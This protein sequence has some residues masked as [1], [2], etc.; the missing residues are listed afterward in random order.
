MKLLQQKIL[1]EIFH[2]AI[3]TWLF[4]VSILLPLMDGVSLT[5]IVTI[6][7]MGMFITQLVFLGFGLLSTAFYR[8]Y[9]TGLSISMLVVLLLFIVAVILEYLGSINYLNFLSPFR[10]FHAR[11]VIK[12]GISLLYVVIALFITTLSIYLTYSFY[13]KRDLYI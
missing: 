10:Y 4:N 1:V 7:T 9:K 3:M 8:K 6:T 13:N 11:I 12:K 5:G 2:I